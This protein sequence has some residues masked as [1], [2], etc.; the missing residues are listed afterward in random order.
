MEAEK[1]SKPKKKAG[2]NPTAAP[3]GL[4]R[5]RSS[6]RSHRGAAKRD[7]IAKFQQN[8]PETP[9]V[10]NFKVQR[11]SAGLSNGASIKQKILQWC[12]SKTRNYEGVCIEN[13]SSSWCDGLAFCALVHRFFPDTFDFSKL[14]AEDRANNFALAFNTAESMADCCPLLERPRAK[15]HGSRTHS[16]EL[17]SPE[18]S[19]FVKLK[20]DLLVDS[21]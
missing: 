19:T 14:R 21:S 11:T 6:A 18:S 13:F 10:P 17:T 2:P 1:Q 5:P 8:C 7:I 16:T 15:E 3:L 20:R 4:S 12:R 9:V